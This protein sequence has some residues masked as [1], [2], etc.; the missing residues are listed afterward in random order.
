MPD[1]MRRIYPFSKSNGFR[2]NISG[3][4]DIPIAVEACTNLAD[5]LWVPLEN[6]T[7]S[8]GSLDFM[9]ADSAHYPARAYRIAAP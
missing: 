3:T 9:D 6:T 1:V 7:L 8:G 4:A 5:G 2:F